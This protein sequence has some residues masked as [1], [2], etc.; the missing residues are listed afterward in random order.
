MQ[1]TMDSNINLYPKSVAGHI[2]TRLGHWFMRRRCFA[3]Y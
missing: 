3:I 1:F 2:W